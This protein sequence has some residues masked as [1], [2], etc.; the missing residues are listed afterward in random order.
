MLV[1]TQTRLL[2]A[3][4][5]AERYGKSKSSIYRLMCYQPEQL[6][7]AI[8][9]GSALRWRIEDVEQWENDKVGK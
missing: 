5:M 9:I 7:P 3:G 1:T 4:D 2:N 6:P 8:H